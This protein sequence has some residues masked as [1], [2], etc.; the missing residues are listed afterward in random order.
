MHRPVNVHF[1][2]GTNNKLRYYEKE[3]SQFETLQKAILDRN[4]KFIFVKLSDEIIVVKFNP[5]YRSFW[6][7]SGSPALFI[8]GRITSEALNNLNPTIEIDGSK[9]SSTTIII[10]S[11]V[12]SVL[13]LLFVRQ[14]EYLGCMF[15]FAFALLF[16]G[17]IYLLKS[18]GIA[19]F[20]SELIDEIE[21]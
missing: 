2:I 13:A 7:H 16:M 3:H 4:K 15:V 14:G 9:I 11:V 6:I 20:R 12:S 19:L 8:E 21:R 18:F 17:T 1:E 5:L 10:I